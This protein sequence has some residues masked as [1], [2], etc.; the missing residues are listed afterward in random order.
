MSIVLRGGL[1][2]KNGRRAAAI[3]GGKY[4]QAQSIL[5]QIGLCVCGI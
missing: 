4:A 1:K 3:N 5:S 2:T